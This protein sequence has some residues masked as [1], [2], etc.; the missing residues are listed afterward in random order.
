MEDT[1]SLASIPDYS[2]SINTSIADILPNFALLTNKEQQVLIAIT[3][4]RG[5]S[6]TACFISVYGA[7]KASNVH[8]SVFFARQ[9]VK[10]ALAELWALQRANRLD[11]QDRLIESLEKDAFLDIKEAYDE[12][13]NAKPIHDI[14]EELRQRITAVKVNK[15]GTTLEFTSRLQAKQMLIDLLGIGQ[16]GQGLQVNINLGQAPQ[17]PLPEKEVK[18]IGH[19]TIDI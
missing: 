7:Y 19:L 17:Q 13:G 3:T 18:K 15:F 10:A 16:H 5:G 4:G 14:P 6:K 11:L 1:S 8:A 2:T 9:D 12:Q